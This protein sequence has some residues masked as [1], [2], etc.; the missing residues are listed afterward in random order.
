[1]ALKDIK[2]CCESANA[3]IMLKYLLI[4][5]QQPAQSKIRWIEISFPVLPAPITSTSYDL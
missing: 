4:L 1:M 3:S 2:Y 5:G